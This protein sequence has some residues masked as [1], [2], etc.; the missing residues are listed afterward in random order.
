MMILF[1]DISRINHACGKHANVAKILCDDTNKAYL[2]ATRTIQKG[3][4]L[5]I[6]YLASEEDEDMLGLLKLKYNFHCTCP[7]H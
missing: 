6:D 2:M 3:D 4:E 7:A 5:L 1:K